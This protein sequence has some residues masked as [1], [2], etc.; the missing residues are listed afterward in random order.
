MLKS[1]DELYIEG[2]DLN[3]VFNG[4]KYSLVRFSKKFENS[5]IFLNSE[6]CYKIWLFSSTKHFNKEIKLFQQS[7]FALDYFNNFKVLF[8]LI[9]KLDTATI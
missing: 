8:F 3:A 6:K 2:N 9:L 7:N 1:G 4:K 5:I